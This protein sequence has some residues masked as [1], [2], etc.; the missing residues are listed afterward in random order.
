[1]NTWGI[2]EATTTAPLPGLVLDMDFLTFRCS[3][4]NSMLSNETCLI[5]TQSYLFTPV[6]GPF[7]LLAHNHCWLAA[8]AHLLRW[9]AFSHVASSHLFLALLFSR[10]CSRPG[11]ATAAF[12]CCGGFGTWIYRWTCLWAFLPVLKDVSGAPVWGLSFLSIHG[13]QW[14][15]PSL[16]ESFNFS[17]DQPKTGRH[18]RNSTACTPAIYDYCDNTSNKTLLYSI[19]RQ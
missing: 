16:P 10:V 6:T 9:L 3:R 8:T 14:A 7:R 4:F 15:R 18:P 13:L 5:I 2:M 19:S 12:I 1:M 17:V 11:M